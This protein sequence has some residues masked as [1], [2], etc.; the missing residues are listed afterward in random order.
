MEAED[1]K[2]RKE[3]YL[4]EVKN[5]LLELGDLHPQVTLFVDKTLDTTEVVPGS[6]LI[7][8]PQE[9]MDSEEGKDYFLEVLIPEI[10]KNLNESGMVIKGVC[11]AAEAYM[12][13]AEKNSEAMRM[14]EDGTWKELPIQKE[15]LIITLQTDEQNEAVVFEIKRDGSLINSSGDMID[16]IELLPEPELSEGARLAGGIFSNLYPLFKPS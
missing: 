15:V 3:D 9:I 16:N 11:W 1:Y 12:R 2:K 5:Q 7:P 8:I 6:V 14:V 4:A 13:K 10:T